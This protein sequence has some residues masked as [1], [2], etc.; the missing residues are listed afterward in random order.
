M[1]PFLSIWER[2]AMQFN[3]AAFPAIPFHS[4]RFA[5]ARRYVC[6]FLPQAMQSCSVA[7]ELK[8]DGLELCY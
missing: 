5:G 1:A 8:I 3:V 2:M 6:I 4:T 7:L